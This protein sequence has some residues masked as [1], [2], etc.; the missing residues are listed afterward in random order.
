M[1][2]TFALIVVGLAI[3]FPAD[4][5]KSKGTALTCVVKQNPGTRPGL[6]I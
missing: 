5:R 1:G 6:C 4:A 2:S 3:N